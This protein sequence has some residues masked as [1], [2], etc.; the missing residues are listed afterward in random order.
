M[1]NAD[2]FFTIGK[3]HQACQ[4]Y[5]VSASQGDYIVVSDGCSSVPDTDIGARILVKKAE[6]YLRLLRYGRCSE[7][8]SLTRYSVQEGAHIIQALGVRQSCLAATLLVAWKYRNTI[9][10]LVAGDGFV[11]GRFRETGD[12]HIYQYSYAS[13]APFYLYYTLSEKYMHDYFL[14]FG[15][16]RT[17]I[18]T[19]VFSDGRPPIITSWS[20]AAEFC[21]GPV[22]SLEQYD[23][24]A[25]MTDGVAS[26][27]SC[28]NLIPA[29]DVI[30]ELLAFK[31]YQGEFVQ[32]R[33]RRAFELFNEIGWVN[34]DDVA[35]AA[36]FSA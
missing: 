17:G 1:I 27:T 34:T 24:V 10:T 31:T 26:F 2:S 20:E 4:D 30:Q 36:I 11:I 13:G 19:C 16:T 18:S 14:D 29:I 28:S 3:T 23:L 35:V 15:T 8:G 7:L 32:R 5:A 6:E 22:F 33:C 25:M 21:L 9:E 12:L